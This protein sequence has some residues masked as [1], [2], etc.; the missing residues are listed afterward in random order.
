M[1]YYV[2]GS[3]KSSGVFIRGF[4]IQQIIL[5]KQKESDRQSANLAN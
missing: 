2:Y 1:K 4:S 5:E 3:Y